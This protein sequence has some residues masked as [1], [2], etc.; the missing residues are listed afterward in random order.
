MNILVQEGVK[1]YFLLFT[2]WGRVRGEGLLSKDGNNAFTWPGGRVGYFLLE[3]GGKPVT[4]GKEMSFS[5]SPSKSTDLPAVPKSCGNIAR[6]ACPGVSEVRTFL[7]FL[8]GLS[9]D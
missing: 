9:R 1:R 4:G 6:G 2:W 3:Q 7:S 8:E 5:V